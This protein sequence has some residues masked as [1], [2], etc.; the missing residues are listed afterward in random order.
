MIEIHCQLRC[1]GCGALKST[2]IQMSIQRA[3]R[4]STGALQF[5]P[6]DYMKLIDIGDW[7]LEADRLRCSHC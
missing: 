4:L 2:V 6:N 7:R 3:A 5:I 1:V